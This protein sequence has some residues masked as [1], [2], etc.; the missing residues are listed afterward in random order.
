MISRPPGHPLKIILVAYWVIQ[1]WVRIT[2]WQAV[3]VLFKFFANSIA[4]LIR[5]KSSCS[6]A[7][8]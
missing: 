5:H 4:V 8:Q 7:S 2:K 6:S 1:S 3:H